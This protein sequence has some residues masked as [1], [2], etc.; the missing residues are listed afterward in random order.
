M[1]KN[2]SWLFLSL[3]ILILSACSPLP[4]ENAGSEGQGGGTENN[5]NTSNVVSQNQ[6][7]EGYYRPALDENGR[8]QTSKNRGITLSLNFWY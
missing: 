1:K 2:K 3:I 8:Y 7:G 6:L 4:N 5:Q